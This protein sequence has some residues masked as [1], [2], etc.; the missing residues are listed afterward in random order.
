MNSMEKHKAHTDGNPNQNPHGQMIPQGPNTHLNPDTPA[1]MICCLPQI[2]A[3]YDRRQVSPSAISTGDMSG[4]RGLILVLQQGFQD[5]LTTV[6]LFWSDGSHRAS[7]DASWILAGGCCLCVPR[8]GV[9]LQQIC[10][11][12]YFTVAVKCI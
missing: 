8:L 1:K 6:Q 7:L 9:G 5:P 12:Q 11:P 3:F 10:Q 2:L 4:L